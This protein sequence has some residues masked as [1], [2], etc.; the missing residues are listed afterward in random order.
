MKT[1]ILVLGI[2]SFSIL[3]N[4]QVKTDSSSVLVAEL[5]G[6]Y[7]GAK[8]N[9]L[10]NG[11]GSAMGQNI[12]IGNFKNGYPDGEGKYIWSGDDYYVG[13]FKKGKRN[14]FGTHYLMIDG[15]SSYIEGQWKKDLYVGKFETDK[16]YT[17]T[18]KFGGIDRISYIYKGTSGTNEISIRLMRSGASKKPLNR[19]FYANSGDV[20]EIESPYKYGISN[21]EFPFAGQLLFYVESK[22]GTSLVKCELDFE[23]T[24]EGSWEIIIYV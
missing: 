8:L 15:K 16:G 17:I 23:L 13:H 19:S 6:E 24:R 1:F 7:R 10:A 11:Q 18:R 21:I 20:F 4:A 14:G 12:Y 2:V 5:K 9:G 3:L 22:I